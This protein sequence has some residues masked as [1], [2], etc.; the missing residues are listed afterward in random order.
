M[1]LF[2]SGKLVFEM[3]SMNPHVVGIVMKECVRRAIVAIRGRRFLFEA[4]VKADH[5]GNLSDV[6]TNADHDAQAIYLK[7]LGECFP[8]IPVIAEEERADAGAH[9]DAET[10]F[11]VDPLDGTKAFVRKQS[12]GIGTMIS[13]VHRGSVAAAYV[14]D[15]MTQEVFGYRP[16]S[17]HVYRVSEFDRAER[18]RID[19]GLRLGKQHLLLRAAPHRY[20]EFVQRLAGS[21]DARGP[22]KGIE[23]TS[24]SIGTSMAR[25]WKGEVG[26][27]ALVPA[28]ET[29]WDHAPIVGISR[30]LGFVFLRVGDGGGLEA[31]DPPVSAETFRRVHAALVIH[32]SRLDE[33]AAF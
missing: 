28:L 30:K 5:R 4:Q 31:Y 2:C 20:P 18:L 12:H 13:L 16:D 15:V 33:L 26:A 6:V 8:G 21:K 27:A 17:P 23:V 9:G 10:Y 22:F 24:G 29:P 1:R 14:G 32:E 7:L 3:S 25:L 11:T 19:P